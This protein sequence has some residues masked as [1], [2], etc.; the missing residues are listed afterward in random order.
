MSKCHG[1]C[2]QVLLVP[3]GR[4]WHLRH[5]NATRGQ[6]GSSIVKWALQ[7]N[8]I[9]TSCLIYSFFV[10]GSMT[11]TGLE[12]QGQHI[13][14]PCCHKL[15]CEASTASL[16][17]SPSTHSAGKPAHPSSASQAQ[18]CCHLACKQVKVVSARESIR[19]QFMSVQRAGATGVYI[20]TNNARLVLQHPLADASFAKLL[21][22]PLLAL[23]SSWPSVR[24][25][26]R[27]HRCR[28]TLVPAKRHV[29]TA[30]C[31]VD[32]DSKEGTKDELEA[33]LKA[34]G[35]SMR[36]TCH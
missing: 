15:R 9:V 4:R 16:P 29:T 23:C 34:S 12:V 36:A 8:S 6:L 17:A 27:R 32:R 24:R 19:S 1:R 35:Q 28:P 22:L 33:S 30:R 10:F 26:L 18:P 25:E 31:A 3:L 11:E 13:A 5:G 2:A 20:C 21:G 14:T 7:L